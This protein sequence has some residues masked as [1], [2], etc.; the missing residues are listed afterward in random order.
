VH[1][2][3]RCCIDAVV[4]GTRFAA[5]QELV[6]PL[7]C[8]WLQTL[9]RC[10]RC[11]RGSWRSGGQLGAAST[12][13]RIRVRIRKI[14]H[15]GGRWFCCS[16]WLRQRSGCSSCHA[17]VAAAGAGVGEHHAL[18]QGRPFHSMQQ[19]C[20]QP[21]AATSTSP[22]G[23]PPGR[24]VGGVVAVAWHW[25]AYERE[26]TMTVGPRAGRRLPGGK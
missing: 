18:L 7:L 21:A 14:S 15:P 16:C 11:G 4:G 1:S 26:P 9:S 6:P 25:K 5:W 3:W 12:F 8:G 13:C 23:G 24:E 2:G 17:A 22:D 19:V 10:T 20:C